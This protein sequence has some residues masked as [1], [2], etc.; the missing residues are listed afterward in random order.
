[1]SKNLSVLSI[2]SLNP[3]FLQNVDL[4]I[5]DEKKEKI[6]SSLSKLKL[7]KFKGQI[8]AIFNDS[9]SINSNRAYLKKLQEF[10]IKPIRISELC[11]IV[12]N[13]LNNF[14]MVNDQVFLDNFAKFEEFNYKKNNIIKLTE[15]ESPIS[16]KLCFDGACSANSSSYK[17]NLIFS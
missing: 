10:M 16:K 3:K 11:E 2:N 7:Y 13:L 1:M 9:A 4:I 8:I 6:S 17:I 12:L 14:E 15:K 5:L